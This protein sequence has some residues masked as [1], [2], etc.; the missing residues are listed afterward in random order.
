MVR[1]TGV[2]VESTLLKQGALV[3]HILQREAT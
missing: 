1:S 3:V 2:Q